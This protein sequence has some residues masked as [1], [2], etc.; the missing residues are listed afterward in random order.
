MENYLQLFPVTMLHFMLIFIQEQ[1]KFTSIFKNYLL[2]K[3]SIYQVTVKYICL[4]KLNMWDVKKYYSEL[5]IRQKGSLEKFFSGLLRTV[6]QTFSGGY[7]F[8]RNYTGVCNYVSFSTNQAFC[9]TTIKS[10]GQFVE[11]GKKCKRF[12]PENNTSLMYSDHSKAN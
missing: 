9:F 5:G 8:P 12:F 6:Q 4:K 2:F 7:H 1:T 11:H 10:R 3:H